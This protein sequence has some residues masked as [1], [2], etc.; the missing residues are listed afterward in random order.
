MCDT[1]F[2]YAFAL[3]CSIENLGVQ[4]SQTCAYIATLATLKLEKNLQTQW[5]PCMCKTLF[6]KERKV[7][8]AFSQDLSL[9][10]GL[11]GSKDEPQ[12]AHSAVHRR[13]KRAVLTLSAFEFSC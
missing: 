1:Q 4:F 9:L 11:N 3:G 5:N 7:R 12:A 8:D 6:K 13:I 2:I 10:E